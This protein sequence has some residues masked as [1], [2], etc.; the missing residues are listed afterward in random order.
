MPS[1]EDAIVNAR[2]VDLSPKVREEILKLIHSPKPGAPFKA[3]RTGFPQEKVAKWFKVSTM[4]VHRW[5]TGA[6]T[7]PPGYSLALRLSGN[8]DEMETVLKTYWDLKSLKTGDVY[9]SGRLIHT[10]NAEFIERHR[11][12]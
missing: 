8:W 5:E 4:Q 1:S 10:D 9:N 2:I 12:K 6:T 3:A 7:P 11:L